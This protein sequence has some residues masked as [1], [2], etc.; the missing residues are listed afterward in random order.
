MKYQAFI[1]GILIAATCAFAGCQAPEEH[2]PL[3]VGD[4]QGTEWLIFDKSSGMDASQVHFGF[5]EDGRYSAQF[6]NQQQQGVWRT[7]RDKLYTTEDGK[8][9]IMVKIL[10]LDSLRLV[11]EMNRG[12]QKETLKLEKK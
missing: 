10:Q 8:K 5:Q 1:N 7:E 2:N 11:F 6:G 4:W 12:G 9:E 3:V